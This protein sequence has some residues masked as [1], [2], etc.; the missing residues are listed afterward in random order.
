MNNQDN[1]HNPALKAYQGL[2]DAGQI[3]EPMVQ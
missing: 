3:H 1:N 2:M